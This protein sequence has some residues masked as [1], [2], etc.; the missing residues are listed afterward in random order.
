[1]AAL[2]SCTHVALK[3][4]N[5]LYL[6]FTAKFAGP[7][8]LFLCLCVCWRQGPYIDL[9]VWNLA[10]GFSQHRC[11]I[12]VG[13]STFR[14]LESSL[15]RCTPPSGSTLTRGWLKT[16][17]IFILCYNFV[18]PF[19]GI[20]APHQSSSDSVCCVS[21][22]PFL[23]PPAVVWILQKRPSQGDHSLAGDHSVHTGNWGERCCVFQLLVPEAAGFFGDRPSPVHLRAMDAQKRLTG[24][25]S[26]WGLLGC[27]LHQLIR[28]WFTEMQIPKDEGPIPSWFSSTHKG[29]I[30]LP[31]DKS[32]E[33]V[34][35]AD[36]WVQ[37]QEAPV[38]HEHT[39]EVLL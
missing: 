7:Q 39:G 12:I 34:S 10:Q 16:Y 26:E 17:S 8:Q 29:P 22:L 2:G 36:V 35:F 6:A 31:S 33:V 21:D 9:R 23:P 25:W 27:W 1:M 20:L 15:E 32:W 11:S 19:V 28:R 30:I 13:N 3:A 18:I 14:E 37:I 5:T 38:H 24:I 4:S